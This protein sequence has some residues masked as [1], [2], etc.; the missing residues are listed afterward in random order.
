LEVIATVMTAPYL[1]VLVFVPRIASNGKKVI[2]GEFAYPV[3]VS[4]LSRE[5]FA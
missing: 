4:V 3:S 5:K 2:F 1:F